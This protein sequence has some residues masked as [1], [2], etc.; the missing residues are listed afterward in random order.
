MRSL[1]MAFALVTASCSKQE[2][3]AASEVENSAEADSG[4][5]VDRGN[6]G[7][8]APEVIF[9]DPEGEETSL[10]ELRGKPVLLN[11]WASW[12]APCVKELPTLDR[13]AQAKGAALTVAAVSQDTGPHPS[14]E[15]FLKGR[16]I[17]TLES[18]HDPRMGLSGGLGAQVLPTSVLFDAEG[19]EVWR[20]V[21]DLDWT[22]PQAAK[23]LA[24]GGVP[25]G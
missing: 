4:Q 17:N 9:N 16:G 3:P 21:G 24:E 25:A 8:P 11:L 20:Y 15:A 2:Q 12:C 19:R 13:L 23:L 7:K 6:K 14:V 10:A 18:Y 1:L 22:G 5:G